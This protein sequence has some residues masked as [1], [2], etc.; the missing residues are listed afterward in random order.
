MY[1]LYALERKYPAETTSPEL[2]SGLVDYWPEAI[3][4]KR[5]RSCARELASVFLKIRD[6]WVLTVLR[7][8]HRLSAISV[9]VLPSRMSRMI[10]T[11]LAVRW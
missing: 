7:D 1:N 4:R 8:M 6:M 5:N 10:S 9:F 2:A 3:S 11:S